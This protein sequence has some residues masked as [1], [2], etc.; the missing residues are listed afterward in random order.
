MITASRTSSWGIPKWSWAWLVLMFIGL[1]IASLWGLVLALSLACEP[2]GF[3]GNHGAGCPARPGDCREQEEVVFLA[4]M[5]L[6]NHM[7]KG[8]LL[9]WSQ[10]QPKLSDGC[11]ASQC[12]LCPWH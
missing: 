2:G 6:E 11:E 4:L 9:W 12:M 3:W 1:P 7:F 10:V 5:S 8:R